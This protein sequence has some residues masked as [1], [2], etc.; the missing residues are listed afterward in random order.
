MKHEGSDSSRDPPAA[1]PPN[2][3]RPFL[4]LADC[5]LPA[6][7]LVQTSA[8]F[9]LLPA[10]CLG[11]EYIVVGRC[12]YCGRQSPKE[13]T[14]VAPANASVT[15]API[16]LKDRRLAAFLASLMPGAGHFYQGRRAKAVIFFVCIF[17]TYM[18]GLVLGA[19]RVVY[20]PVQD[21][22]GQAGGARK[23][24]MEWRQLQ[25]LCQAGVGLPALPAIV[26]CQIPDNSSLPFT[27]GNRW[28]MPPGKVELDELNLKLNRRF[29]LGT[30]FTMIAGLLNV[31]AICD[32]W[33][34]PVLA[35]KEETEKPKEETEDAAEP[36]K[37]V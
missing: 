23:L 2:A 34:G 16:D 28:Y 3:P 17:C 14:L 5:L 8:R 20:V 24:S 4:G 27:G 37:S 12:E 10:N 29:E 33:G 9:D 1:A 22:P 18:Y 19:G 13:K 26:A 36:A 35:I 31:L 11:C 30:V 6:T 15:Q 21:A 7:I 32:A 25:F